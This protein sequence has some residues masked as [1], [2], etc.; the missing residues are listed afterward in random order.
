MV[1]WFMLFSKLFTCQE[2]FV[3]FSVYF[4]CILQASSADAV[5]IYVETKFLER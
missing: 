4:D 1:S 2:T 5:K 3:V